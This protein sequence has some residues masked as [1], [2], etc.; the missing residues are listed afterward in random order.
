MFCNVIPQQLRP[1]PWGWVNRVTEHGTFVATP[2]GEIRMPRLVEHFDWS[3]FHVQTVPPAWKQSARGLGTRNFKSI[4][5]T[6]ARFLG[7]ERL[8][9]EEPDLAPI[10]DEFVRWNRRLLESWPASGIAPLRYFMI[11][12]DFA[13]NHG[14]LMHP[15]WWR[16]WI[17]PQLAKLFAL[18]HEHEC[19]VIF[20]S[21]GD[22]WEVLD[23]LVELGAAVLNGELVG[24]M[25]RLLDPPFCADGRV[26]YRGVPF[27]ENEDRG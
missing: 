9:L 15:D 7:Y 1:I 8:L 4:F 6:A 5:T 3:D 14:L 26:Q 2:T 17:K 25:R 18:G 10:A 12:D 21:D 20:H 19:V 27:W 22:I 23:D 16:E 11:G 24:Q 13:Y